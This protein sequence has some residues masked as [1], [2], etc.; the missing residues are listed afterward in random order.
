MGFTMQIVL[1]PRHNPGNTTRP[2]SGI[3]LRGKDIGEPLVKPE[4]L[5]PAAKPAAK[6]P[7]KPPAKVCPMFWV[8]VSQKGE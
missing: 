6:A 3:K 4:A 7:A 1:F 8:P 2:F 5:A